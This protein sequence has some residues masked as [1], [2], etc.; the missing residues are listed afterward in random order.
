MTTD[1]FA[2]CR[3]SLSGVELWLPST[4]ATEEANLAGLSECNRNRPAANPTMA[5]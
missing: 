5:A 4:R 3:S 1:R 2:D